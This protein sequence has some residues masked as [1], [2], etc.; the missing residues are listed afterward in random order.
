MSIE[1]PIASSYL[2]FTIFA[3]FPSTRLLLF[4]P[5]GDSPNT[6]ASALVLVLVSSSIQALYLRLSRS[7]FWV[8]STA[9]AWSSKPFL[10]FSVRTRSGE[11]RKAKNS[12]GR[13]RRRLRGPRGIGTKRR[14]RRKRSSLLYRRKDDE[15]S[16]FSP[17]R[18]LA[19]LAERVLVERL[20][21]F[22]KKVRKNNSE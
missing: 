18:V 10:A 12:F 20:D 11:T 14:R 6:C 2:I 17:C 9:R 8:Q 1:G 22:V 15:T 3:S 4:V 19:H 5:P 13:R 7:R 21:S 16:S